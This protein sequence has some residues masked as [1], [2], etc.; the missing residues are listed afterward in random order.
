MVRDEIRMPNL[1]SER[2][3]NRL[4]GVRSRDNRSPSLHLSLSLPFL[5]SP[6]LLLSL[7]FSPLKPLDRGE[8]GLIVPCGPRACGEAARAATTARGTPGRNGIPAGVETT[9]PRMQQD[10][11]STGSLVSVRDARQP[12]L[13][14]CGTA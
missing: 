7:P 4:D 14:R 3:T 13:T 5:L 2:E 6:F 11:S 8:R 12:R 9:V 1:G 10:L